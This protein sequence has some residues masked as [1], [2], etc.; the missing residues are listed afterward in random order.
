[1]HSSY[2]VTD[3]KG[4]ILLECGKL[5]LRGTPKVDTNGKPVI[6]ADGKPVY[7]PYRIKILNLIEF[8]KSMRYN[9]FV[10]IR[11]EEDIM[12]LV[13]TII[14]N[15]KGEGD[16]STEDFWVK[17]ERLYYSALIGYIWH[18][19]CDAEKNFITLLEMINA[20]DARED[21]EDY[22][23]PV[24]LMFDRLAEKNPGHFA[25]RQYVKY[26]MAA[27]EISCKWH[28]NQCRIRQGRAAICGTDGQTPQGEKNG[29]ASG[30][31]EHF[32]LAYDA[33]K[34]R[35]N[36]LKNFSKKVPFYLRFFSY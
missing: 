32:I 13:N 24:D 22:K 6:G 18:E 10:Y 34:C 17:A 27:G 7:E 5:L 31:E 28:I 3:P 35:R 30:I 8:E 20:S 15:T 11:K 36:F 12:K 26:K 9:P 1:M 29:N 16:K 21:D 33:I 25:V 2:V 23:N 14:I 19:G 4:T